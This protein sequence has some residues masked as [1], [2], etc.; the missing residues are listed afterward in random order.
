[1]R[2]SCILNME[3]NTKDY[4]YKRSHIQ[5]EKENPLKDKEH[6]TL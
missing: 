6:T 1:M 5:S 4:T 3:T 2:S